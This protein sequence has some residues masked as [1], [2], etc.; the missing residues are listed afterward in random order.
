MTGPQEASLLWA[1]G[2]SSRH[3]TPPPE[4][5]GLLSTAVVDVQ[6]SNSAPLGLDPLHACEVAGNALLG[7]VLLVMQT[8][9]VHG[10]EL[11]MLLRGQLQLQQ[12][13]KLPVASF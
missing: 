7:T 5:T 9:R 8:K 6:R 11:L 4:T 2:W 13:G 3:K 1:E 12:V 10:A